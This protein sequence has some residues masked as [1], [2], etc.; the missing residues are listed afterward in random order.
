MGTRCIT[1]VYNDQFERLVGIYRQFD[2]YPSGHG[3]EVAKFLRNRIIINGIPAQKRIENA[4]N[5]MDCL[6][7][8]LIAEL[9]TDIGNIYIIP[10]DSENCDQDYEYHIYESRV[11]VKDYRKNLLF[12]GTWK[13]FDEFCDSEE[14]V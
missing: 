1:F 12:T 8:S 3:K 5:G 4:S 7:A 2:G 11:D 9:K 13:Q 6:A 10:T 14:L